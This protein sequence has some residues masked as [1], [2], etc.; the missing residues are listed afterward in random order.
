LGFGSP[1]P[2]AEE[3]TEQPI[4]LPAA[5]DDEKVVEGPQHPAAD[6]HDPILHV[7]HVIPVDA[8]VNIDPFVNQRM[9]QAFD[10]FQQANI[11]EARIQHIFQRGLQYRNFIW[12]DH[13]GRIEPNFHYHG[14]LTRAALPDNSRSSIFRERD[15]TLSHPTMSRDES[16]LR[17]ENAVLPFGK[18]QG[19]HATLGTYIDIKL[20]PKMV[21]IH[22]KRGVPEYALTL[23]AKRI[24]EH[25]Q[26][27][28]TRILKKHNHKGKFSYK[29]WLSTGRLYKMSEDEIKTQ[30]MKV[31]KNGK[32]STTIM[33]RQKMVPYGHI[34]SLW[35]TSFSL[36]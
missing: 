3:K 33:V 31:T 17:K 15:V 20:V 36:L 1:A 27:G 5:L 8:P 6:P 11:G 35:D 28:E 32:R 16:I 21:Y 13:L 14:V 26:E 25:K 12:N 24:F 18:I 22:I 2:K 29:T 9:E 30:M 19:R 34:M 23:L 7:P 4:V 10:A